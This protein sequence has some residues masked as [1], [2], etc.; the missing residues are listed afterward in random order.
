MPGAKNGER[1]YPEAPK[2]QFSDP[3]RR[4]FFRPEIQNY[5]Y[6]QPTN[7]LPQPRIVLKNLSQS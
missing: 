4:L 1:P 5:P 7:A 2:S 3:G 6:T